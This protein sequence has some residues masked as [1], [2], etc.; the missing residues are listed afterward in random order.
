MKL[1]E[2]IVDKSYKRKENQAL[3]KQIILK[4][5]VK[6]EN[7]DKLADEIISQAQNGE[8]DLF[9]TAMQY[10]PASVAVSIVKDYDSL[11]HSIPDGEK[12]NEIK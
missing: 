8:S 7:R 11:Q 4:N 5:L 1:D 10:V 6:F 3:L 2:L 12:G 9:I